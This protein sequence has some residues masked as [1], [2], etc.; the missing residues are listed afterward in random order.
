[1]E[2]AY[3]FRIPRALICGDTN[4]AYDVYNTYQT[5]T[6]LKT[7]ILEKVV[8]VVRAAAGTISPGT[9]TESPQKQ[10]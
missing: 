5:A 4:T 6:N 9:D 8:V 7:S 3:Q 1:M 2:I 10:W